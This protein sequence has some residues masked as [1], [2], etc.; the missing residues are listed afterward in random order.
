M[1]YTWDEASS[2]TAVVSETY[3]GQPFS[4]PPSPAKLREVRDNCT[5]IVSSFLR[6]IAPQLPAGTPLCLAVPAWRDAQGHFTHLPLDIETLGF[7]KVLLT[8]A[9]ED[10]LLYYREG[11]VV[12]R[13]L[14]ILQK[15][16]T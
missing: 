2:L 3:L 12:A 11:Q 1:K 8:H 4:A 16:I 14:L 10:Q 6:N 9:R 7:T 15:I 5:H 13:E